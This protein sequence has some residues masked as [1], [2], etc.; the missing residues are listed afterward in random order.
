MRLQSLLCHLV[1]HEANVVISVCER[2]EHFEVF[3][4]LSQPSPSFFRLKDRTCFCSIPEVR[5]TGRASTIPWSVVTM[6]DLSQL[7]L[8]FCWP[9]QASNWWHTC[10]V[11][12][13]RKHPIPRYHVKL[14]AGYLMQVVA[15]DILGPSQKAVREQVHLSCPDSIA[16]FATRAQHRFALN[17][18]NGL[19]LIHSTCHSSLATGTPATM[20]TTMFLFATLQGGVKYRTSLQGHV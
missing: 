18:T 4:G 16:S 17:E 15:V 3:L 12:T 11:C 8:N 19:R 5:V 13:V 6:F 20:I 1:C 10:A 14:P 7:H 2:K 9:G